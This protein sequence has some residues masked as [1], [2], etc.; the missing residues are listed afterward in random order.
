MGKLIGEAQLAF[1]KGRFILDGVVILNE[2]IEDAKKMKEQRLI[3]KVDFEKAY[4]SINWAYL[5]EMLENMKLSERWMRWIRECVSSASVN[6]LVNGS[7]SGEFCL[8]RG[9][10]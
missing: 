9:I 8:G 4:D 2:I 1:L 6:V 5:F 10:R 3:F 7:P